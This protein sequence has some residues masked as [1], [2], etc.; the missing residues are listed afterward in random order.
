MNNVVLKRKW[1]MWENTEINYTER[2]KLF[3][4]RT[5]LQSLHYKVFHRKCIGNGNKK[6]LNINE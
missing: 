3:S 1:K 4:I 2:K 6:N 5:T